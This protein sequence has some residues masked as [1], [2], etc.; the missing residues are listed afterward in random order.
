MIYLFEAKLPET[1]S[2]YFGLNYIYGMGKNRSFLI[3]RK[4]GFSPNLKI[5]NLSENQIHRISKLIEFLNFTIANDLKRLNL[6]TNQRLVSIKSYRGLRRKQGFPVRGQRTHTN[7]A[8][9]KR[10]RK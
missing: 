7:A 1:K 10:N 4:L 6:L 2:I 5:Q 8:T 9:A 3:C